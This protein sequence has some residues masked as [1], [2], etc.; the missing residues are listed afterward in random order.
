MI[1]TERE[2]ASPRHLIAIAP[3]KSGDTPCYGDGEAILR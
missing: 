1:N 2:R 3:V